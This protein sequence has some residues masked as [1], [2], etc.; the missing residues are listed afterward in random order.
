MVFSS[1]WPISRNSNSNLGNIKVWHNVGATFCFSFEHNQLQFSLR[2]GW[3]IYFL[4]ATPLLPS[5][6]NPQREFLWVKQSTFLFLQNKRL[7]CHI[8]WQD[9]ANPYNICQQW[10]PSSLATI[11]NCRWTEYCYGKLITEKL[12]SF[13]RTITSVIVTRDMATASNFIFCETGIRK[14]YLR[15]GFTVKS[16]NYT[17][18]STFLIS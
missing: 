13:T 14:C 17:C 11:H 10:N 3:F 7:V 6:D 18:A 12:Q 16:Q 8:I 5:R 2:H 4:M 1:P 9:V 15:T